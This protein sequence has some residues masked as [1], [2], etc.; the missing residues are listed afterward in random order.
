MKRR[1]FRAN[2]ICPYYQKY[3]ITAKQILEERIQY[4]GRITAIDYNRITIRDQK[5]R[6][7]SCSSLGNINLNYKLILLPHTVADYIIIHEL[8]HRVHMH[9]KAE[10]WSLLASFV[11]DYKTQISWLRE[12]E[13]QTKMDARKLI[14]AQDHYPADA[15]ALMRHAFDK[16][17]S[18]QPLV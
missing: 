13:H 3:R 15:T 1:F 9:H 14:K 8:C 11:P 2:K 17:A 6:W 10:F 5:T 18:F 16:D 4:W 12:I 7:G